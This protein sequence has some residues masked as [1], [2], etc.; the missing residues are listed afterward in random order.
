MSLTR[1]RQTPAGKD[2]MLIDRD[3]EWVTLADVRALVEAAA[4]E[5][6]GRGNWERA[7]ALR[8]LLAALK[9]ETP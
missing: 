5:Y 8:D 9:Q 3:G 1:Y 6:H 2:V 4:E 7:T